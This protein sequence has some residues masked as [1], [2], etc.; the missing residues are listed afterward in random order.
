MTNILIKCSPENQ[1]DIRNYTHLKTRSADL[2][3][4]VTSEQASGNVN[5]SYSRWRKLAP[6]WLTVP[7]S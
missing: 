7:E 3:T 4:K 1:F 5:K 2:V 6:G